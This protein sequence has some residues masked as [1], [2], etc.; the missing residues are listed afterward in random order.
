M[1]TKSNKILSSN[2]TIIKTF[3]QFIKYCFSGLI[4]TI[5]DYLIY[6]SLIN[7]GLTINI[8]KIISFLIG[9]FSSFILNKYFIFYKKTW[10]SLE[11]K[12]YII[13]TMIVLFTNVFINYVVFQTTQNIN[14]SFF[15]AL[16]AHLIVNFIGQKT[17][18]FRE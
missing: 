3:V 2:S 11:I 16:T 13:L 14:I 6:L 8:S 4:G 1:S 9:N 17:W 10:L 7:L 12:K 18:V 15:F 5:I